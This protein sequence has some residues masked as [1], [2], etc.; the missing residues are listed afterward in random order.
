MP[1]K[2]ICWLT[3]FLLFLLLFP[4]FAWPLAPYYYYLVIFPLAG[5]FFLN[6]GIEVSKYACIFA[7]LCLFASMCSGVNLFGAISMVLL[8]LVFNVNKAF[9]CTVY[10]KF[11]LLYTV[12]IALSMI[13]Y[14]LVQTGFA[15]PS[16]I[17]PPPPRNTI[18]LNYIAY[19]FY[20]RPLRLNEVSF[21]RFNGMF[22]EP[23]TVGTMALLLLVIEKCSFKKK[24]NLIILLSGILSFSL[25]FY[26]A[27]GFYLLLKIF[28]VGSQIKERLFV[29]VLLALSVIL[30]IKNPL[31]NEMILSRMEWDS[32]KS[33]IVGNDRS[34]EELT[35]YVNSIRGTYV[36]LFGQND[37]EIKARFN[38]SSSLNNVI[39]DYGVVVLILYILFWFFYARNSIGFNRHLLFF[40]ALFMINLYNRPTLFNYYRL[41]LLIIMVY[42]MS[43]SLI[44]SGNEKVY[45]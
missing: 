40:M 28:L 38:E 2:Y 42:S 4:Y 41:F 29:G 16:E 21:F 10:E 32:D 5:L 26:I 30:V 44:K 24:G 45:R 34:S 36:Y 23:G 14:A 43:D 20:V 31:A 33:T 37:K 7:A 35:E 18:D 17:L 1:N 13:S 9:L 25:F 12:L 6:K 8:A 11:Y 15:L 3:A 19:P 27:I 39:L 22:D